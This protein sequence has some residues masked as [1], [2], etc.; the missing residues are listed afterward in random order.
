M[1]VAHSL[2]KAASGSGVKESSDGSQ[3][4]HRLLYKQDQVL[5]P[6]RAR[7]APYTK[8]DGAHSQAVTKNVCGGT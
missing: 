3:M 2:V 7:E 5:P 4:A 6:R 1:F 8:G